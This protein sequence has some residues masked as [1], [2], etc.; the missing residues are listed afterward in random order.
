MLSHSSPRDPF[1]IL[2]GFKSVRPLLFHRY[3]FTRGL[4]LRDL[5]DVGEAYYANLAHLDNI[6]ATAVWQY[7]LRSIDLETNRQGYLACG[8][9]DPMLRSPTVTPRPLVNYVRSYV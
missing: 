9:P 6:V 3:T 2:S 1:D 8:I 5:I 4:S 7:R